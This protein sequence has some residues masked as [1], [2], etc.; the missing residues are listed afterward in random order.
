MLPFCANLSQERTSAIRR[1]I[2]SPVNIKHV[3][4]KDICS[5]GLY[6]DTCS[7]QNIHLLFST[8]ISTR[9]LTK[10]SAKESSKQTIHLPIYDNDAYNGYQSIR[11]LLKMYLNT[12]IFLLRISSD[13]LVK[14]PMS[15]LHDLRAN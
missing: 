13:F 15:G 9:L 2:S 12:F 14:K 7:C 11:L 6:T 10:T 4:V 8:M 3:N 1:Q 5:R